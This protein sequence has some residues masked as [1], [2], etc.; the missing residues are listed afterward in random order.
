[1]SGLTTIYVS[2]YN[3]TTGKGWTTKKVTSSSWIF[4]GCENL[5]GGNGTKYNSSYIDKI[6]ARI[7]TADA[8]GYFTKKN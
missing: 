3:S 1:M 8:P 7:D 6:Y 4:Y 5:V 2:E